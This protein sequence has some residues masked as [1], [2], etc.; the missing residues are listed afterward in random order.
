MNIDWSRLITRQGR[1][2]INAETALD[3]AK[4]GFATRNTA[5]AK[6]IA[7]IQDRLY[8][9]G[10]GI[11]AG[12]AAD[13]DSAEHARLSVNLADWRLYKFALL[14][15]MRQFDGTSVDWPG[16]PDAALIDL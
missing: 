6:Q 7:L 1:D 9:L 3:L 10:Y 16:P 8:T 15:A 13:E 14:K 12:Q 2:A 5:A 11:E 4:S